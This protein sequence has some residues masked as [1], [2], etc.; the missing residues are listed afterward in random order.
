MNHN[1]PTPSVNPA[2]RDAGGT[3]GSSRGTG[4]DTPKHRY[5]PIAEEQREPHV[6]RRTAATDSPPVRPVI[7]GRPV[8]EIRET[9][10]DPAPGSTGTEKGS[11]AGHDARHDAGREAG[12]GT[13]PPADRHAHARPAM[14]PDEGGRGPGGALLPQRDVEQLSRRLHD[15]VGG[16]VDQPQHAV[17]EADAVL[18]AAAQRLTDALAERRRTLRSAW[19]A[20][21]RAGSGSGS[22]ASDTENLRVALTQYRDLAERLLGV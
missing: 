2:S 18:E 7:G 11:D 4:D 8:S 5:D 12:P 13:V 3:A 1:D 21:D 17:Q 9:E 10:S 22:A 15:A 14:G 19:S 16:F 6:P 20:E